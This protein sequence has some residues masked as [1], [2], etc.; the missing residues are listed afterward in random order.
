MSPIRT[1]IVGAG[2]CASALIQGVHYYRDAA[3]TDTVP[4]IMHVEFGGYHI[5]DIQFV[6]AF[7]VDADKV[8]KDLSQAIHSGQN[9]TIVFT[10]VPTLNV[11][12]LRGPTLDGLGDYYRDNINESPAN[13]VDVVQAL[14]DAKA[15]VLVSYLPVGSEEADRFYAQCALDAGCA[16][17]NCL[18]VFIASDPQWADQIPPSRPPYYWRRH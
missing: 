13:P 12:V 3:N 15:E 9:N 5:R 17:V 11:P 14:K 16:F 8:G 18:P 7:D 4:G 6:A 1:A 2:N 10:E